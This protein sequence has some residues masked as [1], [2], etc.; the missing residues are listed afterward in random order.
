MKIYITLATVSGNLEHPAAVI[1]I[2]TIKHDGKMWLVPEWI[3]GPTEGLTMPARIIC[4]DTLRHQA[5]PENN[6]ADFVVNDPI[7]KTILGGQSP[8]E[9]ESRYVVI[10]RP[11]IQY[12]S[13]GGLQ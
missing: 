13:P 1:E 9:A 12:R 2:D 8:P 10:E 6:P 11:D 7:P 4:L 3:E 5:M